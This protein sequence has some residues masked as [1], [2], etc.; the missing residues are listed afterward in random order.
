[1]RA[2]TEQIIPV[3]IVDLSAVTFTLRYHLSKR[4]I[5]IYQIGRRAVAC[6]FGDAVVVGVVGILGWNISKRV[7]G[8]EQNY[9]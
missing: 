6:G 9:Q 4:C 1:M 5:G 8:E 3:G 7:K 2:V